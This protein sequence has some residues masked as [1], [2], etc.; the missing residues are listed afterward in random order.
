MAV[1]AVEATC[2]LVG[3]PSGLKKRKSY[4]WAE[5]S[6]RSSSSTA[7]AAAPKGSQLHPPVKTLTTKTPTEYYSGKVPRSTRGRTRGA[8]WARCH[9][10]LQPPAPR[11][12]A[13]ARANATSPLHSASVTTAHLMG[14]FKK[15]ILSAQKSPTRIFSNSDTQ[16]ENYHLLPVSMKLQSRSWTQ[17]NPQKKPKP[18]RQHGAELRNNVPQHSAKFISSISVPL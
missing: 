18:L 3:V 11:G 10:L 8:M 17:A 6:L 15:K 1:G 7:L 16:S 12:C 13:A 9:R 2:S 5:Q 14:T 4:F